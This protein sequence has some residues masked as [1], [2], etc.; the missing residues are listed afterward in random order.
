MRGIRLSLLG[1]VTVGLLA[2]PGAVIAQGDPTSPEGIDWKLT[3]YLDPEAES[4]GDGEFVTLTAVPLGTMATLRLEGGQVTGSGGCNTFG[5]S[6]SL[7]GANLSFGDDVPTTLV[8]CDDAVQVIE[9]AYL[10]ALSEVRSWLISGGVLELADE[11]GA[12][13]LTFEVPDISLTSSELAGLV[14]TLESLGADV[15]DLRADLDALDEGVSGL[16]VDRLRERIRSLE[17][18]TQRL[19]REL[20]VRA[21]ATPEPS[22]ELDG[23]EQVL[24]EAVPARIADRCE[25]LRSG[26]PDG[27]RAALTCRPDSALVARLDYFLMEGDDA[28]AAFAA[29][30][31]EHDVAEATSESTT[32]A[33]GRRSQQVYIG[34][35]WQAEGCYRENKAAQLRFVDNATD[36]K[37]LRVEGKV[38]G[39][40]AIHVAVQGS[41]ND[42]A[43]VHDWATRN[44]GSG[45]SQ[46]TSITQ[47]IPSAL[48]AST[49][50]PT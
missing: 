28:A 8:G 11:T 29:T 6:Y 16:G 36:C 39:S 26:L 18:T 20:D 45:S 37:K 41:N 15:A 3:G 49:S 30:M 1:L 47:Y 33:A 24:L 44:V 25:P 5:G 23:P 42:V 38:L 13:L 10:A 17:T 19:G 12:T 50:C 46:L 40:P 21:E 43:S 31:S 22:G 27:A 2:L 35:G 4:G 9:D 32:C 48:G 14:V 34:N 7:D